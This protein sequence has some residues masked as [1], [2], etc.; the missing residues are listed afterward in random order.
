MALVCYG[1]LT[2]VQT[3]LGSMSAQPVSATVTGLSPGTTYH[4]ALLASVGVSP[5][6]QK[7]VGGD[8]TFT[9]QP[10]PGPLPKPG[11]LKLV[12]KRLTVTGGTVK[13]SLRCSGTRACRG[14]LSIKTWQAVGT[15]LDPVRCVAGKQF[16]IPAGSSPKIKATL[17]SRCLGLLTS[18]AGHRRGATLTVSLTSGQPNFST[19]VTLVGTY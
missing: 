18:A 19:R 17:R 9:T 13:V 14:G 15:V 2:P 5:Y 1:Q 6:V 8:R 16:A 12:H 4:F 3:T 10:P 11:S 7:L